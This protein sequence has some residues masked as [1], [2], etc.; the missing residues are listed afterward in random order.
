MRVFGK[1]FLRF[2]EYIMINQS[3]LQSRSSKIIITVRT[4]FADGAVLYLLYNLSSP[5]ADL[6]I[7]N[8]V[9]QD[10]HTEMC[11]TL[12]RILRISKDIRLI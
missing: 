2:E 7:I 10:S 4:Y 3:W 12:H 11:T 6:L 9:P 5:N 8:N 1:I